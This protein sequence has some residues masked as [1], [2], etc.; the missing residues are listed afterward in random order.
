[1]STDEMYPCGSTLD[2]GEYVFR[3]LLGGVPMAGVWHGT[4]QSNTDRDVV[5]T[6]RSNLHR[7]PEL[8]SWLGYEVPGLAP[9]L[10]MGS[11][12]GHELPQRAGEPGWQ[13]AVVELRPPGLTLQDSEPLNETELVRFGIGLCDTILSWNQ[14]ALITRGLRPETVYVAGQSG[15]RYYAGATPR[16]SFL[17]SNSGMYRAFSTDCYNPPSDNDYLEIAV[18]DE[19]FVVGLLLWF[20][21]H[22]QHAYDVSGHPNQDDNIWEDIRHPFTGPPELGRL[23]EA[24]LVADPDKRM[25]AREFRDELAQL[26]R[27][28][29]VELPPFPPPGL[30]ELAG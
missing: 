11:P 22:R 26:A 15:A 19:I 30:A 13:L 20:A 25:K 16:S 1:M 5:I 3:K 4:A 6:Y 29:D 7:S 17:L 18:D 21:F 9:L 10:F 8:E 12:D 27:A 14:R 2:G 23:L 28:W 24:V